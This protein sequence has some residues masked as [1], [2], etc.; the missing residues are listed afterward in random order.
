MLF[1][2]SCSKCGNQSGLQSLD[3]LM[4]PAIYF[5][6]NISWIFT[7]FHYKISV[8][9]FKF[10]F[11][12][13]PQPLLNVFINFRI[14]GFGFGLR[15][16]IASLQ[17]ISLT[18]PFSRFVFARKVPKLLAE[19]IFIQGFRSKENFHGI[20]HCFWWN[21]STISFYKVAEGSKCI[22]HGKIFHIFNSNEKF[23]I[24]LLNKNRE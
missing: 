9:S 17:K 11:F 3:N 4:E 5:R 21:S 19:V 15:I 13:Y 1:L 14:F 7:L 16:H 18:F 20:V 6:L 23:E 8:S 22:L 10:T 2:S 12:R 24:Y